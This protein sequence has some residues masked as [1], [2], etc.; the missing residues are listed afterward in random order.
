ML[1][2]VERLSYQTFA[3]FDAVVFTTSTTPW[4]GS[5]MLTAGVSVR[6]TVVF[7]VV[8]VAMSTVAEPRTVLF[9]LWAESAPCTSSTSVPV[10]LA[11]A[12][13]ICSFTWLIFQ[14]TVFPGNATLTYSAGQFVLLSANALTLVEMPL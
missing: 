13:A 10:A 14:E 6:S 1:K 5:G 8:R 9:G 2:S 7:V 3:G 4:F 12:R 11:D